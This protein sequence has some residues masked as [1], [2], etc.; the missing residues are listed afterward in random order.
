MLVNSDHLP[1]IVILENIETIPKS[2]IKGILN[3]SPDAIY[4]KNEY[5]SPLKKEFDR[6]FDQL[7]R[8]QHCESSIIKFRCK[9][10]CDFIIQ[11]DPNMD[12]VSLTEFSQAVFNISDPTIFFKKLSKNFKVKINSNA[13]QNYPKMIIRVLNIFGATPYLFFTEDSTFFLI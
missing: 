11:Q 13:N 2:I 5:I 4:L 3:Q 8:S 6:L 10:L 1:H 12:A 7:L 9:K